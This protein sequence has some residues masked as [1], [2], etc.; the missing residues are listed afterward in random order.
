MTHPYTE[1]EDTALWAGLDEALA[2]LEA[3][4][5]LVLQTGRP[6]VLGFLC[7]RLIENGVVP[8]VSMGRSPALPVRWGFAISLPR[9]RYTDRT[10][11]VLEIAHEFAR[12]LGH[13]TVLPEHIAVALLREGQ[14]VGA[15][16]LVNRR[17]PFDELEREL[18]EQLQATASAV[19]D[20]R[21]PTLGSR[22]IL[23]LEQA[24][25]ES[26]ELGHSYVGTE[27]VL[28]SLVRNPAEVPAQVLVRHGAGWEEVRREVLRL[29]GGAG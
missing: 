28:L 26:T 13:S 14:G 29:L 8:R 17:V 12:T 4:D 1:F 23:V 27:H 15:A 24:I 21:E 25:I 7:K 16:S 11:K 3:D 2:S 6:Y 20:P 9:A 18:G 5:D 10:R 19:S 22:A